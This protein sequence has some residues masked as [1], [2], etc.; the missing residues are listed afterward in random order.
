MPGTFFIEPSTAG[1]LTSTTSDI[2]ATRFIA[3]HNDENF[4][5]KIE[6]KKG[7]IRPKFYFKYIKEKFSTLE[8]I[9]LETNL[10]KIEKA[11]DKAIANGQ[12]SLGKKIMNKS[13]ILGKELLIRSKGITYFI[14]QKYLDKY[15][16]KIRKG[17]IS[18]T[19]L[20][21]YTRI[22]PDEVI[23]KLN[24]VKDF[25]DDFVIYHYWN[26]DQE[27]VKEMSSEEKEDMRDPV[28][29]GKI[30]ETDRLYFIADWEDE[31]CDLTFDEMIE[32]LGCNKKDLKISTIANFNETNNQEEEDEDDEEE[33][34]EED[35]DE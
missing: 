31:Y 13:I 26:E 10:R 2:E 21:D 16:H 8:K 17:H 5:V 24:K 35:E 1:S 9:K 22:I 15:K 12:I 11:F 14:E 29:F 23:E 3:V 19:D 25:F 30:K 18:D 7:L 28:L 33:D 20:E 4:G 6:K 34:Y 27:D 32:E